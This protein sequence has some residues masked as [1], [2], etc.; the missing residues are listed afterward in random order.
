[1]IC[2]FGLIGSNHPARLNRFFV[3]RQ[4]WV[5]EQ[6]SVAWTFGILGILSVPV[7]ITIAWIATFP[8]GVQKQSLSHGRESLH[9]FL[10]GTGRGPATLD[11]A[12]KPA[13]SLDAG[14]DRQPIMNP[15]LAISLTASRHSTRFTLHASS[16]LEQ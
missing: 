2:T 11:V 9:L 6:T 14:I 8:Q 15:P 3:S 4:I 12:A 1:M 5:H 10:K 13:P 7:C 16:F